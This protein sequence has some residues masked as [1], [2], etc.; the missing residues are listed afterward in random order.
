MARCATTALAAAVP[1]SCVR[2][3]RGPFGG[4]GPVPG[5]ASP[6]SPPSRPAC[7]ALCVAG[8][9]V[10][11][12]LA[13]ARWYAIPCGLCVPRARSSCPSGIPRVSFVCV[14]ARAPAASALPP[15]LLRLM[16]RAHFVRSWCPAL[17]GPFH[18][19]GAPPRFPPRSRA[20]F[21]LF[22]FVFC[23]LHFWFLSFGGRGRPVPFPA[24]LAWGCVPRVGW[25]CASGELPRLGVGWGGRGGLCAVPPVCAAG[26]PVGLG[27]ALPQSDPLPSLGR[28]Q[29]GCSGRRSG[30]RGRGRHTVPARSLSSGAIHVTPLCAGAGSLVHCGSC[31]SRRPGRGGGPCSDLPPGRSGPASGRG[32][33]C[34]CLGGVGA[35][36]PVACGLVGGG[37]GIGGDRAVAPLPLLWGGRPAHPPSRRRRIPSRCMRSAGVVGQPAAGGPGWRGGGGGRS[38]SRPSGGLASGPGGQEVV[39]PRSVPL[40]SMGGQ[41]CGCHRRRSGHGGAAPILLRFVVERRPQAWPVR[42]SC[43]L[44]RVRPPARRLC[45]PPGRHGPFW[46]RGDAPSAA[47]GGGRGSAPRGGGGSGAC[48]VCGLSSRVGRGAG[49]LLADP[50]VVLAWSGAVRGP[51]VRALRGGGTRC[52]VPRPRRAPP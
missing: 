15:L 4:V 9:P 33:L 1:W 49:T 40:P 19:V 30:F 11:V 13:L 12:S 7:P 50:G 21:G 41:H 16:W 36:V 2:G 44:V 24:Y 26:E 5:V 47:G 39:L 14:C 51:G 31:G 46:G 43:A 28:Q 8:R 17:V 48:A 42:W 34:Y 37:G 35:G 32:D 22:F 27:V 10:Q 45:P 6:P 38:V 52:V 18:S 3:A 20:P 29:S 23:F 25:A